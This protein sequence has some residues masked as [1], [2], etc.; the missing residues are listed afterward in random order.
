MHLVCLPH[1]TFSTLSRH[2]RDLVLTVSITLSES[3]LGL[4]RLLFTHLDG[5]G[6]RSHL[7]GPSEPGYKIIKPHQSV[8][9]PGEG[10]PGGRRNHNGD[11]WI[12]WDVVW[13]TE[14]WVKAKDPE[15]LKALESFLP[16]KRQDP[17]GSAEVTDEVK[18]E[19]ADLKKVRLASRSSHTGGSERWADPSR[20]RDQAKAAA[21]HREAEREADEDDDDDFVGG[22]QC[23]VS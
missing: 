20:A 21:D 9:I 14:D 13:P 11:L 17:D 15:S 5:R 2:S 4:D 19:E 7:P 22:P 6:I 16:A 3:L 18:F 10:L 8:K 23:P 1:K 12:K